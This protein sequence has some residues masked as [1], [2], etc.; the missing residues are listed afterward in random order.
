M[1]VR[2]SVL[3]P[4]F[5]RADY[6]RQTIDSILSQTF[7]GYEIFVVDDGSTDGSKINLIRQNNQGAE[8]ARNNAAASAHGE[9]LVM[10]DH[11]DLLLPTAL[12]IY[13]Q[14]IREFVA[15]PLIVGRVKVFQL[16][17]EIPTGV[18]E[19]GIQVLQFADYISKDV[20]LFH[21][22]SQIVIKKEIFDRV[23]GYSSIGVKPAPDDVNLFLRVGT[24]G[25][26]IAVLKPYTIAY[27]KHPTQGIRNLEAITSG[28]LRLARLERE[29]RYPG[30][31]RRKGDRYAVIGGLAAYYAVK[32]CWA[33]GR[34]RT[35]LKLLFGTA[36]MIVSAL[37]KKLL[38]PLRKPTR[39]IALP[40]G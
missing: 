37:R 21:T 11:D 9:Y 3:V 34:R 40:R 1:Q 2:F 6:V 24:Y 4:V 36:P 35:A 8:A 14:I 19:S 39:P 32:Y 31:R 15:P 12:A 17:H 10:L 23:G 22:N 16:E 25:P 18:E 26:C 29:G 7:S 28:I 5:N 20:T 27:R 33:G 30:G 13:D 38:K